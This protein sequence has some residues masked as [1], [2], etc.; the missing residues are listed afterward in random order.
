ML[1]IEYSGWH[2]QSI[3]YTPVDAEAYSLSLAQ[4]ALTQ[5]GSL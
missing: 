2:Q 4:L 1:F 3:I 5:P